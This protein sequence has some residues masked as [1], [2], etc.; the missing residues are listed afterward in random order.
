M[1]RFLKPATLAADQT[2]PSVNWL[3]LALNA[4]LALAWL[5]LYRPVLDYLAL[6]ATVDD[7]R[8]N[9]ILLLGIAVLLILE[10]RDGQLALR[11]DAVPT[12]RWPAGGLALGA[13]VAFLLAERLLDVNMLSAT[14]FGLA[15]YGLLGLWL[16]P[17]R[18]RSSLPVALLLI[19]VLPFGDHLQTFVGYPLRIVTAHLVRDGL[20]AVGVQSVGVDTILVFETGVSQID[21]PCSGIKSLWTGMLFLLAATAVQRRP[22]NAR[23]LGIALIFVALLFLAN[24]ARVAALVVVGEVLGLRMLAAMLHVPLGVL[25]FGL[26]CATA[27]ALLR[28]SPAP[29]LPSATNRPPAPRPAVWVTPALLAI[30]LALALLYTPRPAS[31]AVAGAAAPAWLFPAALTVEPQPLTQAEHD[32]LTGDGAE[33]AQRWRFQWRGL[34]GSMILVTSSTWRAHHQP[35]RCFEVYGL[36]LDQSS[37]HLVDGEFPL[38]FVQLGRAQGQAL[39][40]SYW[41]QSADRVTDDYGTRIWADLSPKRARWVLV[42]V[43]FDRTVTP[44]DPDVAA[45][46]H[47]LKDTIA[48]RLVNR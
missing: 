36:S 28:R 42:S 37:T 41:F 38:R 6:V 18:W 1:I 30:T 39:S 11:L 29:A 2:G 47:I 23:W 12:W 15:S 33:A 34:G 43:L 3:Q 40:A 45:L 26:A 4:A 31:R 5:A 25:G 24:L 13:S 32:W 46:Y 20:G 22:L 8:T 14:L 16:T 27:A 9:Q 21:V 17:A 35:E 19:G 7:F 44:D 48:D 10:A